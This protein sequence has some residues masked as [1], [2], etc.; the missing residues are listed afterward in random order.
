MTQG[1]GLCISGVWATDMA[2]RIDSAEIK[3]LPF[4]LFLHPHVPLLSLSE[5]S[6]RFIGA[7]S[8]G[9]SGFQLD[10]TNITET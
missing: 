8:V 9:Q 4:S 6:T 10:R 1:T 2:R 3:T 7:Q 5:Y